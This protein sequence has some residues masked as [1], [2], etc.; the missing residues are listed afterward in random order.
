M[1]FLKYIQNKHIFYIIVA[2]ILWGFIPV[3]VSGLFA[4][5]SVITI[6]YLRFFTCGIFFLGLAL[7]LIYYNNKFTSNDKIP[8]TIFKEFFK[9]RNSHFFNLRYILYFA[10]LGSFGIILQIIFYF[11]ALKLTSIG[12]VMIGFIIFNI[13]IA[14]YQHGRS[15]ELD[16][17][18][19][20]YIVML[21]FSIGIIIFVKI[22]ETSTFSILG[23]VYMIIFSICIT[24]FHIFINKDSYSHKELQIINKN[25]YYKVVRLLLKLSF[26][27]LIGIGFMFIF[28]L[29][30]LL[31]P[32]EPILTA[33]ISKF[34]QELFNPHLFFRWEVLFINIF[35]TILPYLLIF[36]AYVNWSPFNLTYN[37]WSSILTV[38]E[39]LTG[40]FFGVLLINEFFPLPF[41]IITIFILILS[42]LLR[43]VHENNIKVNAL[44]LITTKMGV[45]SELPLKLLRFSGINH[46][47]VLFGA[48]EFLVTVKKSSTKD[49]YFLNEQLRNFEEIKKIKILFISKVNKLS[50]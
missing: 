3:V 46:I 21:L 5:V 30:F 25:K 18:K 29:I 42:I 37:Q 34:F 17:F 7:G 43:Y 40:L 19:I 24:F 23:L 41:L 22:F 44:L 31:I 14:I 12:F 1:K 13:I 8:L 50:S 6:I 26:M 48:H 36:I 16:I 15:E 11:L 2:N 32:V 28:V 9:E 49:F 10:I 33:E 45:I 27:F 39:P 20:L 35:S 38:I 4:T 47:D